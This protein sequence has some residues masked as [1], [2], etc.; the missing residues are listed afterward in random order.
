M[1]PSHGAKTSSLHPI[2]LSA[3]LHHIASPLEPK[4]KYGIPHHRRQTPSLDS[5]TL[6]I[7]YY[8]NVI[9]IL[10]TLLITQLRLYLPSVLARAPCHQ[11]ST[12]HCR[13]F[14]SLLS[15]A[16]IHLHN[17]THDDK[18]VDHVSLFE[19]LTGV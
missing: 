6:T 14:L 12:R 5:L 2:H 18:L 17:D 16:I 3:T 10:V 4:S 19:Q 7:Y 9:S 11:S 8:K 1:L 15:H 13:R